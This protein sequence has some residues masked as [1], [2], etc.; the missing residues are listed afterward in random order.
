M[1]INWKVRFKNKT[2]WL[3]AMPALIVLIG[4]VLKIFNIEIDVD[5]LTAEAE[6]IVYAVFA[7][8]SAIGVVVD[9][10]TEGVTDSA[11]A[12]TYEEPAAG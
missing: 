7:L 3:T 9:P 8:L 1:K 10:T 2:F 4:F 12:L 5:L 6:S 11:R